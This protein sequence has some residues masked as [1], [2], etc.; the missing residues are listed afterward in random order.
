MK[1]TKTLMIAS[2]IF[3]TS[4]T[5]TTVKAQS[6]KA[7]TE[8]T[9]KT[10]T[11]TFKVWGNCGTCKKNIEKSVKV[12]GISKADWNKDTKVMT[13]TFEASK[14]TLEQIQKRIASV[15]Y[16]TELFKGNDKAYNK[17]DKCC[18]YDRK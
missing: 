5:V 6:I 15:G 1:A 4:L 17:L 7:K 18:Q 11:V 2:L 13:I 14:I 12:D 8:T 16:D 3:A 9:K 10:E